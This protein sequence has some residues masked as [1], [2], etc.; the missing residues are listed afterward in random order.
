MRELA[1]RLRIEMAT[2]MLWTCDRTGFKE[3]WQWIAQKELRAVDIAKATEA[4]CRSAS[5]ARFLRIGI[6]LLDRSG[7]LLTPQWWRVM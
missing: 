4:L 5:R 7:E 3:E 2:L 1:D 6:T